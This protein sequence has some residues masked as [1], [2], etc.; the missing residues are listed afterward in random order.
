M[1]DPSLLLSEE[2]LTWLETA[3][4]DRS[5]IVVSAAFQRLLTTDGERVA[6]PF[7]PREELG[8]FPNRRQRLISRLEG[9]SGFSYDEVDLP[10][11]LADVS[12]ALRASQQPAGLVLA[13]EWAFLQSQSW[14]AAKIRTA[15]DAFRDA[16]AAVIEYGRRARD[17]MIGAVIRTGNI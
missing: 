12:V 16:G 15:L 17:E 9:V 5:T 8:P 2:G 13:D 10:S 14:M 7:V 1:L 6:L 3:D 11:Q 4:F